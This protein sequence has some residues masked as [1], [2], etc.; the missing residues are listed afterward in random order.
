MFL[1]PT[2]S[3]LFPYTT[4][5]RSHGASGPARRACSRC[6]VTPSVGPLRQELLVLLGREELG[7]LGLVRGGD[8]EHPAAAVRI[9][10][11][12]L[13]RVRDPGVDLDD[14]ARHGREQVGDRLDRLDDA[15]RLL[16]RRRGADL[17]QLDKD[18]IAELLRRVRGDADSNAIIFPLGPFVVPRVPELLRNV[19]HRHPF[20]TPGGWNGVRTTRAALACPR[21]STA[22]AVPIAASAV[23][24]YAISMYR[25]TEGPEEPDV[26]PP[27]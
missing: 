8:D 5:F 26:T 20:F 19:C 7:P 25:S 11:H 12:R 18:D 16:R 4:L 14:L 23:S 17:R 1:Q 13:G 3:T 2:R 27:T 21:T 22:S 9:R 24:T 15:E 6:T 10:V